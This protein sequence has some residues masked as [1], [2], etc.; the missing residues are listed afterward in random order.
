MSGKIPVCEPHLWANETRYV[1]EA[2][3]TGWLSSTGSYITRFEEEFARFCGVRHGVAV[4]NGTVALHLALLAAGI[5]EGDEVI[6]NDFTMAAP[7]LAILYCGAKP[8]LVD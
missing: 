2:M 3:A 8:V 6:V 7:V 4:S 5:G 1:N